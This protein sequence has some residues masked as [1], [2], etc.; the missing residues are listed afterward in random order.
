M[1]SPRKPSLFEWL[2]C[3]AF[4]FLG[5]GIL[6]IYFSGRFAG[7]TSENELTLAEGVPSEVH[8]S[9]NLRLRGPRTESLEFTIAGYRT[10]YTSDEPK[11]QEVLSAVTSG[12]PIRVWVSTRPETL[13]P[14]RG[15]VPLYKV[16]LGETPVLTYPE[17]A[18]YHAEGARA[19][20][21]VGSAV[22]AIGAWAVFLCYRNRQRSQVGIS[23]QSEGRLSENGLTAEQVRRKK[24]TWTAIFVSILIYACIIGVNFDSKVQ[25][26]HAE[27][28]GAAP[29][30]L[31]VALVV[32]GVETLLYLPMPWVFWHGMWIISQALE[33]G[34]M[35]SI[36]YILTVGR[37]HPELRRSQL[38]CLGGLL[39]VAL[40]AGAWIAYATARGI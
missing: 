1:P 18:A 27:A 24:V 32:T 26:K 31:P 14:A 21:I 4:F 12:E 22:F 8:V 7:T 23:V 37:S 3:L 36:L 15:W 29:F 35:V 5:C 13:F 33:E 10:Q 40:I 20:L 38:V 16:S 6:G 19:M 11:F 39:Y 2:F 30:G 17:I 28:F 25:A 34:W 9:Q